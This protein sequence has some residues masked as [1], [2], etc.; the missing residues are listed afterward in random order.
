MSG[1]PE[2]VIAL[3][4]EL[5]IL[6]RTESAPALVPLT[7]KEMK[8]RK[9]QRKRIRQELVQALDAD[10]RARAFLTIQKG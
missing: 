7:I 6:N 8:G 10:H 1:N 3:I 5:L 2:R 4:R 9:S